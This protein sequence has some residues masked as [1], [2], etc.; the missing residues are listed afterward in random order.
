MHLRALV[1]LL[2]REQPPLRVR[3]DERV[4]QRDRRIPPLGLSAPCADKPAPAVK[5]SRRGRQSTRRT[6]PHRASRR[7]R[8]LPLPR[9][10]LAPGRRLGLCRRMA[11]KCVCV[12]AGDDAAGVFDAGERRVRHGR[13]RS[14]GSAGH[15]AGRPGRMRREPARQARESGTLLRVGGNWTRRI[16]ASRPSS[17]APGVNLGFLYMAR[18]SA[19]PTRSGLPIPW[20]C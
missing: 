2:G 1:K 8:L 11:R 3:P 9:R 13:P 19:S 7:R 5:H 20:Q 14:L 10:P 17:L 4:P 15:P 6:G 18:S 12:A 16:G